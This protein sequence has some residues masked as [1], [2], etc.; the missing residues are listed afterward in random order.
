[1][2]QRVKNGNYLTKYFTQFPNVIDDAGLDVY[3]FRALLHYYRVGECWEGV[4]TTA[5]KCKMS[6]GKVA[7]VR[8]SLEQKGFIKIVPDGDGVTIEII[9]KTKENLDKY[10]SGGE[11]SVQEV[12][13]GVHVVNGMR[14]CG[15]HKNNPIK[16]NHEEYNVAAATTDL[17]PAVIQEKKKEGTQPEYK[18]M[19]DYWLK[20]FH[21]GWTFGGQQ[22]KAI[23]SLIRKIKLTLRGPRYNEAGTPAQVVEFFMVMCQN[24]PT[25]FE[26]KDLSILDQ[27]YNEIITQIENG[28]GQG[29]KRPTTGDASWID[30]LYGTAPK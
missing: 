1:M 5:D 12:N 29:N 20:E 9:D 14:S 4:R 15:E 8:I 17:F 27:K 11:Q 16:N 26:D 6:T 21:I 7:Q 13:T 28:R 22:G 2:R 18:P 24:L 19:V 23:K 25:Y 3:E 10:R 30:K